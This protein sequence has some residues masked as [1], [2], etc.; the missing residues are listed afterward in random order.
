MSVTQIVEKD[1][2]PRRRRPLGPRVPPNLFGIA[3]GIAGLAQAGYAAV[4]VLG[5]VQAVYAR[6]RPRATKAQELRQNG[7]S[8][9]ATDFE[10][11]LR[12]VT[13]KP[14]LA[15]RRPAARCLTQ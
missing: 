12:K 2:S 5:T 9:R 7:G 15:R 4:P 13:S 3:L 8:V 6:S 10:A 14:R 11:W 1:Q